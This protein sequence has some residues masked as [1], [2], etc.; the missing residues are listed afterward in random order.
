MNPNCFELVNE[1]IKKVQECDGFIE[2]NEENSLDSQ[3]IERERSR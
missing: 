3:E 1:T 2:S